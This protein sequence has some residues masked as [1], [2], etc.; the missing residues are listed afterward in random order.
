M[1][2]NINPSAFSNVFVFPTVIADKYL[3]LC[4]GEH[5]KVLIYIMRMSSNKPT[6]DEIAT[7]LDLAAYDVKEAILFWA[8]AGLLLTQSEAVKTEKEKTV[9]RALKPQREDI[10]KRGLEDPKIKYLLNETQLKFGRNLKTNESQTLVWLYDDIGMDVSLILYI[11][12]YA[13]QKDKGNIRF[14]ESLA[15][16][17][18]DKGVE[19]IADAEEQ[20]RLIALSEQAWAVVCRAFGIERRKP[21]KKEDELAQKWVNEWKISS[22]LLKAAYDACVDAKSKLT[23]PYVAKIIEN[24]HNSGYKKTEDIKPKESANDRMQGAYDIDLFEKMLNSKE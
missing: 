16:D 22:E 9:K 7:A 12:E 18:F 19:T 2:Y 10:A 11:V 13:K 5:L 6:V 15:I 23:F 21:T 1:E 24:W 3:K 17:W 20:V 14:I 4:K 8:D